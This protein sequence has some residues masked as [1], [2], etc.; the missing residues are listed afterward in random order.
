MT[1][2]Q[3]FSIKFRITL[4]GFG[5]I[6]CASKT[7]VQPV[8]QN[9]AADTLNIPVTQDYENL[10]WD[11]KSKVPYS[12]MPCQIQPLA[13]LSEKVTMKEASGQQDFSI[14]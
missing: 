6:L 8:S 14:I 10:V 11:A 4:S 5:E 13:P 7:S 1:H 2:L 3:S 9:P 12:E